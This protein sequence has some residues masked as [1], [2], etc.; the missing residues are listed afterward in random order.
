MGLVDVTDEKYLDKCNGKMCYFC[1]N[2]V[3]SY[4]KMMC[5]RVCSVCKEEDCELRD[6][7]ANIPLCDDHIRKL[8]VIKIIKSYALLKL[9]EV[10]IKSTGEI[11]VDP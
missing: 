2:P 6:K 11:I 10:N 3:A 1:T 8:D 9:S 4:V 5:A 7:P